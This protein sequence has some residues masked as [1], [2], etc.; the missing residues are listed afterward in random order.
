MALQKLQ[1]QTNAEELLFWGKITGIFK[2]ENF[3]SFLF[4][5]HIK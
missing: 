2:I 3:V 5:R 4:T 1:S